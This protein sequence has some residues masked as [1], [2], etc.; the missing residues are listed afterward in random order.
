MPEWKQ[1][2]KEIAEEMTQVPQI[3][4]EEIPDIELYMDQLI[5]YLEKRLG[6]FQR[7]NKTPLI[8]ST[9]VNNYSKA[10]LTRPANR[11]RYDKAHVMALSIIC[12]MKRILSI[13]DMSRLGGALERPEEMPPVYDLFL[14]NQKELFAATP[15]LAEEL[16]AKT[17][18][19]GI[20]PEDQGQALAALVIQLSIEAQRNILL[21]ERLI[22]RMGRDLT[23]KGRDKGREE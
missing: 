8:T 3:H 6:F 18:E 23:K 9:M 5:T 17:E 19:A 11:K 20:G 2:L 4:E 22:D 14:K 1:E 7:N 16:I 21:A 15:Q 13:Q 12:Q 10:G